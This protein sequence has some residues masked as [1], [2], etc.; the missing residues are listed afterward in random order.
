MAGIQGVAS[1]GMTFEPLTLHGA[2]RIRMTPIA[3]DRGF[4][5]RAFC[6]DEF[7]KMGLKY[8]MVQSN[9]SKSIHKNT[10]R[11]MHFQIDGA[12]EAKIK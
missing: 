3:D 7:K 12:E 11:G 2:Y 1:G 9:L 10:L 6:A 8:N 4:F 5:A